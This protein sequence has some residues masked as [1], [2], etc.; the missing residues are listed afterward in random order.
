MKKKFIDFGLL[1][2]A[3]LCLLA[4]CYVAV[5]QLA[6]TNKPPSVMVMWDPNVEP[7]IGGYKIYH[8]TNSRI[9]NVVLDVGNVTNAILSNF[10]RGVTYYFAATAYNTIPLESDLS[11]EVTLTIPQIPLPPTNVIATN[12][13]SSLGIAARI[14][15]ADDVVGPWQAFYQSPTNYVDPEGQSFYRMSLSID[16]YP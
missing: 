3:G 11:E 15:S 9:Y 12:V 6:P 10:T 4:F 5:G 8:G 7:D 16:R 1:W 14:E 2:V 13:N